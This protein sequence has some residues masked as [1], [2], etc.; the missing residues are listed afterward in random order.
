[1]PDSNEPPTDLWGFAVISPG[2]HRQQG[3]Q[4]AMFTESLHQQ[5]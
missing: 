4:S 3:C 1:M 5:Q 2:Q